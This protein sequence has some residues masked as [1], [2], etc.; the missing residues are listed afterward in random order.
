MLERTL[1]AVSGLDATVLYATT[2]VPLD[3]ATLARESAPAAEVVVVEPF[4]AGTLAAQ[5][6]A[7]LAH[8]ATRILS[9]G[10]PREAIH[11]YGSSVEHDRRLGLD[12]NGIRERS[13]TSCERPR[14]AGPHRA[15]PVE[16]RHGDQAPSS[17]DSCS[18]SRPW[19]PERS[20]S[21]SPA[22]PLQPAPHVLAVEFENDVNP[23]TR[24]FVVDAIERGED[25]LRRRRDP[26]RHARRA[27]PRWR[28][29]SRRARRRG[30]GRRLRL[31]AGLEAPSAGALIGMAADVLAMAP[32]TNDRLLDSGRLGGED[33]PDD[34]RR[35]V[36][37]EAAAYSAGW[38]RARPQ[39]GHGRARRSLRRQPGRPRGARR[40]T[41]ST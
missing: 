21:R 27:R 9:V 8:R 6:G 17:G 18:R 2:V 34:L 19:Q 7:A 29:S 22:R 35:K 41:S 32:Q 36:V 24:D 40:R 16:S 20:S 4:Y 30:A 12:T 31:A 11:R 3:A 28:T 37:N 5:V 15:A 26:A 1:E 25:E 23:V 39:P 33:I 13:S 14:R 38:R 10:V